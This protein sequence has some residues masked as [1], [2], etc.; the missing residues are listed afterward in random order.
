MRANTI[1]RPALL[2]LAGAASLALAG[3]GLADVF[4]GD[5][6]NPAVPSWYN[7]PSG[8]MDIF[9]HRTLTGKARRVIDKRPR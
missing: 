5:K 8:S 1:L 7:R 3:C 9:V 2:A 4:T 6:V